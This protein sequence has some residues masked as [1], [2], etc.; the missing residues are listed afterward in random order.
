VGL[1]PHRR[2]DHLSSPHENTSLDF[3]CVDFD[4]YSVRTSRWR[5]TLLDE[6]RKGEQLYDMQSDSGEMT[7]LA[8]DPAQAQTVARL[9]AELQN[10]AKSKGR[11]R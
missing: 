3:V 5:Y 11:I 1:S 10:Y 2:F 9:K 8:A 4:G 7:N 6:G